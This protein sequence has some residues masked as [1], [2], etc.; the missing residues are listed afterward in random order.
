MAYERHPVIEALPRITGKALDELRESIAKNGVLVPV[1]VW[2]GMLIDGRHRHDIAEEL[3]IPLPTRQFDGTEE[4]AIAH[5]WALNGPRRH[6]TPSQRAMVA[7][8]LLPLFE[9]AAARRQQ[10]GTLVSNDTKGRAREQAAKATDASP[11]QV[12]RAKK[13]L[14]EGS[15]E[16][17]QAVED[18]TIP[19]ST[20]ATVAGL[21]EADQ[22]AILEA[23]ESGSKE[24]GREQIKRTQASLPKPKATEKKRALS[25]L[26]VVTRFLEKRGLFKRYEGVLQ[27]LRSEIRAS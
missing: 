20:A 27:R 6:M 21:A 5:S 12:A 10:A 24:A 25:A 22:Q 16:L 26:G 7:A 14:D 19:V 1:V 18:G 23:Y 15:P 8:K 13:V 11:T 17:Q 4:E 3:G 2:N 9:D